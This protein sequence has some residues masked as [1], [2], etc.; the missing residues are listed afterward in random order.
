MTA[1]PMRQVYLDHQSSTP[2]LPEVFAAMRPYFAENFGSPSALHRHGLFARDAMNHAREQMARLINAESLEEIIFTSGGTESAN[3]A[4]KGVAYA[5]RSRGNHIIA[6]AIDHPAVLHS[7]DFLEKQ[8]FTS[9][10]VPVDA[11]GRIHLQE[12]EKALRPDTILICLHHANHD[13][14][15]IQP[16]T[17]ICA[18]A[19]QKGIPVFVDACASGGWLP[20]DVEKWGAALV[21][22]SPHR[23]YGPKGVGVLYKSRRARLQPINHGGIKENEKRAGTEN[24]PA[25]VG[26]GAAADLAVRELQNRLAHTAHLQSALWQSLRRDISYLQL[27]G[28]EPGP[29]R[30]PTN[31]NISFEF[32]EGEGIALMADMQGVAIAS[33][34]ACVSK[35]LKAS[36]VLTAMGVPNAVAQGNVII[37]LGQE[38]TLE[39]MDYT[40]Q[41]LSKIVTKLRGM[42]PSWDDFEQ[43]RSTPLLAK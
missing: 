27:N 9:T 5:N 30:L 13:V 33:G 25:I 35:A 14:G 7:L 17:E 37:S 28:P 10:R 12:I 26:A 21:S 34:A 22:L 4:V 43:G 6:S 41:V 36:P 16:V 1:L 11:Q 32:V 8:G 29:E 38:N 19:Q 39:E 24:V 42:S 15:A 18:I 20:I 40:A 2:I 3:L 31:L 23:F